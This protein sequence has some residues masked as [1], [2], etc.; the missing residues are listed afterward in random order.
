[1]STSIMHL[2]SA[3]PRGGDPGLMKGNTG[4]LWGLCNKISALVVGEMWEIKFLNALLSG[5]MMGTS[6]KWEE[7][8]NDRLFARSMVRWRGRRRIEGMLFAKPYTFVINRDKFRTAYKLLRIE[9]IDFFK[10]FTRM[11]ISEAS[12]KPIRVLTKLKNVMFYRG[13]NEPSW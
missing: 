8:R 12:Q 13:S 3:S 9:K 5:R 10:I 4:T 11:L 2:P 7:I 6:L 1:M